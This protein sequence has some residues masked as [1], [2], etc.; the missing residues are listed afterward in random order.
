MRSTLLDELL[1]ELDA[2]GVLAALPPD[3]AADDRWAFRHA[4]I[5]DVAY[6]ELAP[7]AR[8]ALHAAAARGL[9]AGDAELARHLEGADERAAAA[10]AY[11][12]AG[13]LAAAQGA[14]VDALRSLRRARSLAGDGDAALLV[15][16]G[17]A[18]ASA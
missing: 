3:A 6:R 2:R 12:R 11:R 15:A 5:R 16:L 18:A 13:E 4:L 17:A 14:P 9:D 8:R 1:A 10:E 7:G